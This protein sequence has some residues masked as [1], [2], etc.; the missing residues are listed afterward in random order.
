MVF[1]YRRPV[2]VAAA[3]TL[4][5]GLLVPAAAAS[6]PSPAAPVRGSTAM[7]MAQPLMRSRPLS[8]SYSTPTRGTRGHL[9]DAGPQV[10]S[11]NSIE[12]TENSVTHR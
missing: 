1:G 9:A 10:H 4:T 6:P 5:L 12:S 3:A 7:R 8:T 2:Q 11:I